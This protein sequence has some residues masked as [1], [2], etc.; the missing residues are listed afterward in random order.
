M[1]QAAL[2]VATII[3][4][5]TKN[6]PFF[7]GAYYIVIGLSSTYQGHTSVLCLLNSPQA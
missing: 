5:K 7:H 4:I 3:E 6:G 1:C 2:G